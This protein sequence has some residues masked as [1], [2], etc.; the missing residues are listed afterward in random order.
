MQPIHDALFLS[1]ASCICT[2]SPL[3][4]FYQGRTNPCLNENA[5]PAAWRA[6][7]GDPS[8]PS[9]S[10]SGKWVVR[11]RE[12][13]NQGGNKPK[14]HGDDYVEKEKKLPIEN[15]LITVWVFGW[16]ENRTAS[17]GQKKGKEGGGKE[18]RE[19]ERRGRK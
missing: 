10:A 17:L 11:Q 1:T 15:V 2:A 4:P 6:A 5:F 14:E 18:G 16:L 13:V 3:A 12:L 8:I 7:I 19:G 9:A